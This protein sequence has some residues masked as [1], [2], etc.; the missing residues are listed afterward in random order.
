[1]TLIKRCTI[2]V[3]SKRD[4]VF[5]RPWGQKIRAYWCNF[6][7]ARGDGQAKQPTSLKQFPGAYTEIAD[8]I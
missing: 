7:S 4:S 1:M 8:L 2:L 3:R 5:I 6:P